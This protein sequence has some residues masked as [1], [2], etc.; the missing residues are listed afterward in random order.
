LFAASLLCHINTRRLRPGLHSFRLVLTQ[1]LI[2][3]FLAC[4]SWFLSLS[5]M[6][7]EQ[8][9]LPTYSLAEVLKR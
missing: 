5:I 9:C 1:A 3:V 6:Q 4:H 2:H 8:A 7:R